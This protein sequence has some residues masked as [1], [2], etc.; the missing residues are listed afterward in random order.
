MLNYPLP[1]SLSDSLDDDG[2]QQLPRD[3][4]L[5]LVSC[6]PVVDYI[7]SCDH[8]LY[9]CIVDFL[10]PD[11]LRPIPGTLTQAIR[12]FAKSLES[13]L[14]ASLQG[15]SANMVKSK[16]LVCLCV[17][18]LVYNSSL[19]RRWLW[20]SNLH[21]SAPLEMLFLFCKVLEKF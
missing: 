10:V 16:V 12:N 4:L 8:T 14:A 9:Q 1:P 19:Y 15:F 13:W 7:N 17:F 6:Q 11:V 5:L 3:K 18:V 20:S 2:E 21:H